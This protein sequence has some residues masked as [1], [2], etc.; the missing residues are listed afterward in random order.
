MLQRIAQDAL[1]RRLVKFHEDELPPPVNP[2]DDALAAETDAGRRLRLLDLP[3]PL[4]LRNLATTVRQHTL[5]HLNVYLQQFADAATSRGGQVHF[6]VDAVAAREIA[7]AL[8]GG[9]AITSAL[10]PGMDEAG[11]AADTPAG[12]AATFALDWTQRASASPAPGGNVALIGGTFLVAESGGVCVVDNGQSAAKALA[13]ADTIICVAGIEKVVPRPADLTLLLKL[14]ARSAAGQAMA[15]YTNFVAPS[16]KLHVILL[17]NGRS[18]ILGKLAYRPA[19]KC[20]AC[21]ACAHADPVYRKAG[22]AGGLHFA[23]PIGAIMTPLFQGIEAGVE[24]V[25]ASPLDGADADACP[26]KIDLPGLRVKLRRAQVAAKVDPAGERSALR[27]WAWLLNRPRVYRGVMRLQRWRLCRRAR[28][29]GYTKR[30]P[31]PAAAWSAGKD[32]PSPAAKSFSA[33]WQE[34]RS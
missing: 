32:L 29:S 17:D 7:T 13:T 9:R 27:A 15:A 8:A 25:R 30:L 6:A 28:R 3:D 20:I 11:I 1:D 19:L 22:G 5:D 34:K 24:A 26:V 16:A 18:Q 12:A 23:G 14:L 21:G 31:W 2:T 4:T 33:L 10:P